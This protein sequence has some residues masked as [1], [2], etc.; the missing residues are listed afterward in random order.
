[1]LSIHAGNA[2]EEVSLQTQGDGGTGWFLDG[3]AGSRDV[4]FLNGLS[5]QLTARGIVT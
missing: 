3:T 4:D 2:I 5:I 1:M